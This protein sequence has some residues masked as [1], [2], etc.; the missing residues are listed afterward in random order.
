LG[1]TLGLT[2]N[3]CSMTSLLTPTRSEVDH[4]KMSLFFVKERE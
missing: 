2:C 1:L 3:W 4:A